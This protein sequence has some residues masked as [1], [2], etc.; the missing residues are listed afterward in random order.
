MDVVESCSIAIPSNVPKGAVTREGGGG[1]SQMKNVVVWSFVFKV[2]R[3]CLSF[4][5]HLTSASLLMP[6]SQPAV[7]SLA[8]HMI[9][10]LFKDTTS[11]A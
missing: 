9:N 10:M 3:H 6:L 5:A 8:K 4:L 2:Q 7:I 11:A 1:H